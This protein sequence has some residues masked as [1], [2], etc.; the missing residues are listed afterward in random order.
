MVSYIQ[1]CCVFHSQKCIINDVEIQSIEGIRSI[2]DLTKGYPNA[3]L[4]QM[5]GFTDNLQ[6]MA[7]SPS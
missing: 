2:E 1:N 6:L 3:M 5:E 4:I 7:R